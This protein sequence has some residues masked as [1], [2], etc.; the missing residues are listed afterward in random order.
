LDA[1][2]RTHVNYSSFGTWLPLP[3]QILILVLIF[4]YIFEI[5]NDTESID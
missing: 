1:E 4:I 3:E 5:V 2:V